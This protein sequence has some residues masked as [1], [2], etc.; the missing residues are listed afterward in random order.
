[1]KDHISQSEYPYKLQKS[2]HLAPAQ[3]LVIDF[4]AKTGEFIIL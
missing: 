2:F 3:V 1:M 4:D